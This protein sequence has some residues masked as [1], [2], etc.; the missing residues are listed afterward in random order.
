M[1]PVQCN[2]PL[3]GIEI[4]GRPHVGEHNEVDERNVSAN[5]LA[6]LKAKLIRRQASPMPDG[7]S[8]PGVA[9]INQSLAHKYFG[10]DDPISRIANDEGGRLSTWE[11]VGIVDDM[12]EGPLDTLSAPTE[13]F[14]LNQTDNVSFNLVARTGQEPEALLPSFSKCLAPG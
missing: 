14:P 5:Y 12:H 11:I 13:Y 1:L 6:T 4:V 2:C 8:R 10:N 3:D 9:V 7:A